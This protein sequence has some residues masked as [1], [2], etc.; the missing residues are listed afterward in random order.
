M[1][2]PVING[3]ISPINGLNLWVCLRLFHP[4]KWSYFTPFIAGFWAHLVPIQ[5]DHNSLGPHPKTS[6]HSPNLSIRQVHGPGVSRKP[7][8]VEKAL[9]PATPAETIRPSKFNILAPEK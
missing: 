9:L 3:V 4:Y 7:I 2:L 6:I 5:T 8:G 1:P